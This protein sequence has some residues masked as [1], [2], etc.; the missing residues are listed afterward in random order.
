MPGYSAGSGPGCRGGAAADQGLIKLTRPL[1]RFNF[2]RQHDPC[3]VPPDVTRLRSRSGV[4]VIRGQ[5]L[6][7]DLNLGLARFGDPP[8]YPIGSTHAG[9]DGL[10]QSPPSMIRHSQVC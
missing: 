4:R 10:A 1:L 3:A 5:S 6:G 8:G 2:R 7:T 9:S